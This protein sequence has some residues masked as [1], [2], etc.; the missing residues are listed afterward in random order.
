MSPVLSILHKVFGKYE[1]T[2][3]LKKRLIH[4]KK[5]GFKH[6]MVLYTDLST[7]STDF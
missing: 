1:I 2:D 3:G 6:K 7:I 4:I 5:A